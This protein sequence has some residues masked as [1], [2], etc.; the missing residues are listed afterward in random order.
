MRTG[1]SNKRRRK[2]SP[3]LLRVRPW[4]SPRSRPHLHVKRPACRPWR[5][6]AGLCKGALIQPIALVPRADV[7]SRRP[8]PRRAP[9]QDARCVDAMRA[10]CN[11][12]ENRREAAGLSLRQAEERT[13]LVPA[14]LS[15]LEIGQIDVARLNTP[16]ERPQLRQAVEDFYPSPANSCRKA[17]RSSARISEPSMACWNR[18]PSKSMNTSRPFATSGRAAL[19]P[20]QT[21]R[22]TQPGD[23]GAGAVLAESQFCAGTITLLS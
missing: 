17:C 1:S 18:Q 2:V 16:G 13:S 11:N 21:P 23:P 19:T 12:L 22:S 15:R 10:T 3:P 8:S 20:V 5:L 7:S 9:W 14:T 6:L 4:G